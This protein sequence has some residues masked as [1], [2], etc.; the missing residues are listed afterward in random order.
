MVETRAACHI[1]PIRS[2]PSSVVMVE[3]VFAFLVSGQ[4]IDQVIGTLVSH[5]GHQGSSPHWVPGQRGQNF[6]AA[7]DKKEKK[8]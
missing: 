1:E 2:K 5:L 6:L 8:D 3:V 7:K 4:T